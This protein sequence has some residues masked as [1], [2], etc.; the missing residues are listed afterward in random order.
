[1][2]RLF[3]MGDNSDFAVGLIGIDGVRLTSGLRPVISEKGETVLS[4]E[5]PELSDSNSNTL[6]AYEAGLADGSISVIRTTINSQTGTANIIIPL[7]AGDLDGD[8]TDDIFILDTSFFG[9][10]TGGIAPTQGL[11]ITEDGPG[12]DY[13]LEE[14]QSGNFGTSVQV[15]AGLAVIAGQRDVDGDGITDLVLISGPITE[16][17][18]SDYAIVFGQE[19]GLDGT[20]NPSSLNGMNGFRIDATDVGG[21][22]GRGVIAGDL[23]NDGTLEYIFL[24]PDGLAVLNGGQTYAADVDLGGLS[25]AAG[26]FQG[27][28]DVTG[29]FVLDAN[30]DGIVDLALEFGDTERV[31]LGS[32]SGID[33]SNVSASSGEAISLAAYGLDYVNP[34]E[35]SEGDLTP[36]SAP[37]LNGDGISDYFRSVNGTVEVV[38]G[39]GNVLTADPFAGAAD[40]VLSSGDQVLNGT[41]TSVDFNG[42]GIFDIVVG[43]TVEGGDSA[44]RVTVI[45]GGSQI[46]TGDISSMDTYTIALPTDGSTDLPFNLIPIGDLN[47][48]GSDEIAVQIRQSINSADLPAAVILYGN[49]AEGGGGSGGGDGGGTGGENFVGTNGDDVITGTDGNDEARGESGD[50]TINLG[51][52]D[53]LGFGNFG[54]DTLNGGPGNDVLVGDNELGLTGLE[55]QLYR[56]YRAVFN[57]DPDL[58]GFEAFLQEILIG[59]LTFTDA[60]ADFIGSDEFQDTYGSLSNQEFVEQLYQNVLEREGDTAGVN[61]YVAALNSG[62]LT[63]ADVV[64]EFVDSAE[65]IANVLLDGFAFATSVITAPAQ[66]SVYR[67]FQAVFDRDPDAGGFA[68][69]VNSLE[70][71]T[72]SLNDIATE[73][74][75][76]TEFQDTYGSLN[77]G[78]FVDQLYQNVFGRPGD[79]A[80]RDAFVAA[81]ESGELTRADIVLEFAQSDEFRDLTAS[82]AQQFVSSFNDEPGDTLDGGT[83]ND[84]LYGGRGADTFIFDTSN[85]GQDVIADFESGIDVIDLNNSLTFDAIIGVGTQD[86]ADAVFDFG[87]GNTLTLRNVDLDDLTADDFGQ[88]TSSSEKPGSDAPVVAEVP[89]DFYAAIFDVPTEAEAELLDLI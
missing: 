47:G 87:A 84:V 53:D 3:S 59:N 54:R 30:G 58:G 29:I 86:G 60:L 49:D 45:Y 2:R 32:S 15:Q 39:D 31:I 82:D 74:V 22:S 16:P 11:L 55:G 65:F 13:T 78:Q 79:Q 9:D 35:S 71:G 36:I 88:S 21:L 44:D 67:L 34:G 8:G 52:G 38:F 57:R 50:D 19:G 68:D 37:D 76:S 25:G 75:D 42:D 83:G 7:P 14:L 26:S 40:A 73:F 48:D 33:I 10:F 43:S 66:G 62:E 85:G 46:A 81:L 77:N 23:N 5:K 24:G 89:T 41:L 63:R 20:V 69:F 72:I 70:A 56:A 17:N 12:F 28:T 6:D 51:E 61:A 27:G 4:S 1:M 18:P 64:A 80:G